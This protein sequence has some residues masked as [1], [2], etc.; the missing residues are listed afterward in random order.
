M[1]RSRDEALGFMSSGTVHLDSSTFGLGLSSRHEFTGGNSIRQ[2]KESI[3]QLQNEITKKQIPMDKQ[4]IKV[5]APIR[6][7][8]IFRNPCGGEVGIFTIED[9]TEVRDTIDRQLKGLKATEP[10]AKKVKPA[11]K[12]AKK[13]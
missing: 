1:S 8:Q 10:K 2:L 7:S 12:T 4:S 11:K 13:K 5:M 9:A 6:N 3:K